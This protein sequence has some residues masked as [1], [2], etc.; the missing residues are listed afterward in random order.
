MTCV[1]WLQEDLQLRQ[2]R[3]RLVPKLISEEQFWRRYFGHV[4]RVK[5]EVLACEISGETGFVHIPSTSHLSFGESGSWRG[6]QSKSTD[7]Y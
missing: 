2:L 3:F 4:A 5:R 1:C 6:A 7:V